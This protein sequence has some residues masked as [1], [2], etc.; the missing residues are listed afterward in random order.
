V[1]EYS[2]F[3]QIGIKEGTQN[4]LWLVNNNEINFL[5]CRNACA[6]LVREKEGELDKESLSSPNEARIYIQSWLIQALR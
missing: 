3:H 5:L 2:T 1:H 6:A 4:T